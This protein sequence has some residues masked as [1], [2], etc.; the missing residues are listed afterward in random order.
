MGAVEGQVTRSREGDPKG[1]L[2]WQHGREEA[3]TQK[4]QFQRIIRRGLRL[5]RG[6]ASELLAQ[7]SPETPGAVWRPPSPD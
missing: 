7:S 6:R 1:H 5:V 2:G 3:W 4:S